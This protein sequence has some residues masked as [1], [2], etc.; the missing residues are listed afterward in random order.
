MPNHATDRLSIILISCNMFLQLILKPAIVDLSSKEQ[1]NQFY[2]S[3]YFIKLLDV[4]KVW[5]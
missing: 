2:K 3:T 1:E 5:D 4:T